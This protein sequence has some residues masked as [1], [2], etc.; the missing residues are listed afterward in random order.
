MLRVGITG[1]I[2]AGKSTAENI[3]EESG[4]KVFDT[5]KIAHDILETSV[6]VLK[7]FSDCDILSDGKIN[8]RKLAKIVFSVPEKMRVLESI[9]HPV[10]KKEILKIFDSN[11][12]EKAVFISVPQMY[13][14]GFEALF[15]K[16]VLITADDKIRLE[17]LM[18]RNN[19]TVEEAKMRLESQQS[20]NTKKLKADYVIE[21][22]STEEVLKS[23]IQEFLANIK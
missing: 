20:Q 13:E 4:F 1:N 14:T 17:R 21:N 7:E 18:N 9:I 19:L 8:R 11:K 22:N 10:V 6:D 23:R 5:D 3:I 2:A 16:V 15:D 12:N